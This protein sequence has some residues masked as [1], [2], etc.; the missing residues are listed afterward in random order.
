[1]SADGS[2]ALVGAPGDDHEIGAAWLFKRSGSTWSPEQLPDERLR[3]SDEAGP[4][5]FGYSVAL[6]GDASTALVGGFRDNSSVGAAWVFTGSGAS[7]TQQ[8]PKLFG[9]GEIDKGQ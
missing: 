2:A 3:A 9:A 4:A 5:H 1:L 8:G 6:S 7:L